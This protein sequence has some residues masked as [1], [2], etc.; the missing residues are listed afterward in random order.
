MSPPPEQGLSAR[1]WLDQ[2]MTRIGLVRF[3]P[4][5]VLLLLLAQRQVTVLD[6]FGL[7]R[8]VVD[9]FFFVLFFSFCPRINFFYIR[10]SIE[11]APG[12][13]ACKSREVFLC[14]GVL[15]VSV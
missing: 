3:F 8:T 9:C 10:I 13:H 7:F 12:L 1:V 4:V 6:C 2:E 11:I 5:R 15:C 14:A